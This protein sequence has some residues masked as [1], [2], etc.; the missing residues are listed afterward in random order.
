M[1]EY[2]TRYYDHGPLTLMAF[3]RAARRRRWLIFRVLRVTD[4][5]LPPAGDDEW[6]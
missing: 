5:G 6:A 1:S 3:W 2:R 4:Y